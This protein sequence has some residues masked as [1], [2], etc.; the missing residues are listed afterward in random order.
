MGLTKKV[1]LQN[2]KQKQDLEERNLGRENY[3]ENSQK[4][5]IEGMYTIYL[6]SKEQINLSG[7]QDSQKETKKDRFKEVDWGQMAENIE[8]RL[9]LF[10]IYSTILLETYY[11]PNSHLITEDVIIIETDKD[12][13]FAELT[14]HKDIVDTMKYD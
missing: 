5:V 11:L 1:R 10:I 9:H 13:T 2:F 8:Y 14:L 4:G 6:E 3:F 12:P 7:T